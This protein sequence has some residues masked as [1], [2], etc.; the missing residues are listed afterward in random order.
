[1]RKSRKHSDNRLA[2]VLATVTLGALVLVACGGNF[3]GDNAA[4]QGGAPL[5]SV[6]DARA[7]AEAANARLS[8]IEA[9]ARQ[10][11]ADARDRLRATE[12]VLRTLEEKNA[13]EATRVANVQ[14]AEATAIALVAI[15]EQHKA[16][17]AATAQAA[18]LQIEATSVSVR[19]TATAIAIAQDN[20]QRSAE[21]ERTV[22]IPAKT[23]V[24]AGAGIA[25]AVVA[26]YLLVRFGFKMVDTWILHARVFRDGRGNITIVTTP[27][28]DGGMQ[29][30]QPHLS[31]APVLSVNRRGIDGPVIDVGGGDPE[32]TRRAQIVDTLQV[33]GSARTPQAPPHARAE[34]MRLIEPAIAT[35]RAGLDALLSEPRVSVVPARAIPDKVASSDALTALDSDW[36]STD[37]R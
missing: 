19:A 21:W 18:Q 26:L 14:V 5:L 3:Q 35:A 37:E 28:R 2:V 34:P 36:R 15:S 20:A 29:Y 32:V 7:Q 9:R 23:V 27:D 22:L 30:V 24:M 16:Q 8:Q 4:G 6:E 10:A 33:G 11:T 12:T 25:A 13:I 1:M 31:P 17:L